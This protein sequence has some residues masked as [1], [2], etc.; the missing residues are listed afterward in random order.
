MT[1]QELEALLQQVASQQLDIASAAAK[2]NF[3]PFE[4]L[5]FAKVD[6]HREQRCGFPE[7]IFAE[8]KSI[9]QLLA[10]AERALQHRAGCLATRVSAETSDDCFQALSSERIRPGCTKPCGLASNPSHRSLPLHA[11]RPNQHNR[12][13]GVGG[14]NFGLTGCSRSI[15]HRTLFGQ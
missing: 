9:D 7:V 6:T 2:L 10:I 11:L 5:G 15:Q 3:A 12:S 1:R 13:F 8:G 14:G 4:E